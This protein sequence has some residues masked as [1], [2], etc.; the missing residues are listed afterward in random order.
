MNT[1]GDRIRA[2]R[3]KIGLSQE[4]LTTRLNIQ[5]GINTCRTTLTKWETGAQIPRAYPLKC[6]AEILGVSIDW[7]ISGE[8]NKK[9]LSPIKRE[10]IEKV[11]H[12]NDEEIE[13]LNSLLDL[14]LA[15]KTQ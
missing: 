10:F 15:Q 6:L 2:Q 7:L 3:K 13:K 14:F 11:Q 9:E 8:D 5:Y 12:M 4:E 1:L